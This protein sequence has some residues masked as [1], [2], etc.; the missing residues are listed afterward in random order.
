MVQH[1]I[2]EYG[3]IGDNKT[4]NTCFIQMA[5]NE[6][7][8]GD[9]VIIPRGVFISGALFLHSNMKIVFE[10]GAILKGSENIDDYPQ[11][12]YRFE[13]L[14]QLCYG[15]LLNTVEGKN[16]NIEICGQGTVDGSGVELLEK[17]MSNSF[18]Q[19]GRVICIRNTDNLVIRDITICNT[20]AWTMHL[21]FC[22]KAKIENVNIYSSKTSNL[23][24]NN[25]RLRN[26]DGIVIDS[27]ENIE[28]DGCVVDSQ[29]DCISIKSGKNFEGRSTGIPSKSI[30]ISRCLF[31][32]GAGV[33]LG[34]EMSGGIEQ[35]DIIQCDYVDVLSILSIKTNIHRGGY[36][37]NI[38]VSE[39]RLVNMNA[40][41]PEND[42]YKA[43]IYINEYY[44]ASKVDE[45]ETEVVLPVVDSIVFSGI[46]ISNELGK[47]IYING[48]FEA[49]IRNIKMKNIMARSLG[50]YEI[51][52]AEVATSDV[53]VNDKLL[54]DI[55][56]NKYV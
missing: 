34:S 26:G 33:S 38:S 27:S 28:I 35:V 47:A 52:N 54:N 44:K 18:C 24:T 30:R 49:P 25:T 41:L 11:Y 21:I 43:A 22:K 4:I 23:K 56:S 53:Y 15:S 5:I 32:G 55:S 10:E 2:L 19:R 12:K 36:V 46:K 14:E 31:V 48:L 3:A 37:K 16:E 29:D 17:E 8:F 1:N 39:C 42:D 6:C 40:R 51:H 45:M 50:D 7:A 20:V 13:G 9:E